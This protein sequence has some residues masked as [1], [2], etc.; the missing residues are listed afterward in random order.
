[1]IA[2]R[3]WDLDIVIKGHLEGEN[4]IFSQIM[5]IGT[6]VDLQNMVY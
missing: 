5:R 3:K 4:D 1:M 6:A 2:I